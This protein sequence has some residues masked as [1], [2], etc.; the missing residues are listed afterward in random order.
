MLSCP[1]TQW[2]WHAP[3][4]LCIKCCAPNTSR[5]LLHIGCTHFIQSFNFLSVQFSSVQSCGLCSVVQSVSDYLWFQFF[6]I[7]FIFCARDIVLQY[8][9]LFGTDRAYFYC[10]TV[11]PYYRSSPTTQQDATVSQSGDKQNRM[12]C[13]R[14]ISDAY[15]CRLWR[16]RTSLVSYLDSPCA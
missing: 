9:F 14:E 10:G 5:N 1:G 8:L 15:T 4:S 7:S 6:F 13:T 11:K 2:P 16:L 3:L 12:D